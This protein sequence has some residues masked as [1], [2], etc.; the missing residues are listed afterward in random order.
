MASH[1]SPL[2][3]LRLFRNPVVTEVNVT[4]LVF[5]AASVG[6]GLLI[7]S[8]FQIVSHETPMQSGLH[9]LPIGIGAVLTMPIGGAFMDKHGPGNIVLI[10]LPL[11]AAGLGV[12]TYGVA[13]QAEYSPVLVSGLAIM[14]L[15]AGLTTTP[16]SAALMQAL[17]RVRWPA[18]RR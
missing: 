13:T 12:F 11:M 7:P 17:T 9:M 15:G 2:I 16:L 18:G 10:G 8:Y 4:M 1:R 3:D 14:G 5:G 6:V